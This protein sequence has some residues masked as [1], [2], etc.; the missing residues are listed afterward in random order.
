[1][2]GEDLHV[3]A[4]LR[5]KVEG[6]VQGCSRPVYN[7]QDVCMCGGKRG[8][9]KLL[10]INVCVHLHKCEIIVSCRTSQ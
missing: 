3:W 1:M 2:F 8:E 10:Y 4:E 9:R 6:S 5:G 7:V